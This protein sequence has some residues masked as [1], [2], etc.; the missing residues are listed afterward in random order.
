MRWIRVTVHDTSRCVLPNICAN[1][2]QSP[3]DTPTPIV[4]SVGGL[5]MSIT[6]EAK[7]PLCKRCSVWTTRAARLGKRIGII[8][9]AVLAVSALFFAASQPPPRWF[10]NP[11]AVWLLLAS[12]FVAI[13]GCLV[14]TLI[15][16]W[17]P[18]PDSCVTNF[19][20]VK[21]LR[22]GTALLSRKSFA[23][24][25]FINPLYVEAL[26]AKNDPEIVTCNPR[27]L[28]KAKASFLMRSAG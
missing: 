9:S 22:G 10:V 16:W 13:I 25:Q 23:V 1:C 7:W 20:A 19:P 14:A 6:T 15:Q 18:R 12:L 5:F 3:A 2:L 27:V 24:L 28:E 8:P 26:L 11:V 21:P 4:R 17:S